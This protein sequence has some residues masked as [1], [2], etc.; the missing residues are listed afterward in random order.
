[1]C[2]SF[3]LAYFNI[4]RVEYGRSCKDI[5]CR[6]SETCVM[7]QDSCSWNQQDGKECGVYPTCK[8]SSTAT[9]TSPGKRHLNIVRHAKFDFLIVFVYCIVISFGL[10]GGKIEQN[11][12]TRNC[13]LAP[14]E[15]AQSSTTHT[16]TH[17]HEK[18][19][20]KTKQTKLDYTA[21]HTTHTRTHK[22]YIFIELGIAC[23]EHTHNIIQKIH[24]HST[25][26]EI[27]YN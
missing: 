18:R 4:T 11:P 22:I 1:M 19:N 21:L 27:K 5:G 15:I 26:N 23:I 2:F 17:Q 7:A 24:L 6:P 12:I 10:R 8:K 13:A 9:N 25:T 20:K 3:P 14:T 16:H